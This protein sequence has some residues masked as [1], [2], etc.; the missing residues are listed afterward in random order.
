[1][2]ESDFAVGEHDDSGM[3]GQDLPYTLEGKADTV[4]TDALENESD[5]DTEPRA[6]NRD[7]WRNL[8]AFWVIG[9]LNNSAYVIMNAGASEI[10]SGAVGLVYLCNVAPSLLTK[11]TLPY[12]ADKVPYKVRMIIC[13]LAMIMSF[14]LVGFG[15][16]L[17]IQLLGVACSAF[18]SGLGEASILALAS[19]YHATSTLTA[20]SS[21]T[22]FAGVLGYAWVAVIHQYAKVSL[23]ATVLSGIVLAVGYILSYFYLLGP[24]TAV[25]SSPTTG[26]AG[27]ATEGSNSVNA[28]LDNNEEDDEEA[29]LLS[30]LNDT[31][32]STA[33]KPSSQLSGYERFCFIASLWRYII[34]LII[35]YFSEYAIQAGAW[36][37]F[38]FPITSKA[39]R[40]KFYVTANWMYQ[41]G[42]F[43][44]RSS[45][46]VYQADLATLWALPVIQ[47]GLLVFF[48]LDSIF[49][50][51]WDW[52][53]LSVCIVTGL[54]GGAVYVNAFTLISKTVEPH[55][56]ELALT[57]ASVGDSL[58]I[59][60]SNIS[61][62]FIQGCLFRWNNLSGARYSC[63][64]CASLPPS[65]NISVASF[66]LDSL[67]S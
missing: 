49:H 12:W 19:K 55:R 42:V 48:C 63:T 45:G 4:T 35:V 7:T 30:N 20:W 61:S 67:T 64:C 11:I 36:A 41:L 58:G 6:L 32:N 22:G 59:L 5:V 50:F 57:S 8:A 17:Q 60:M 25:V 29:T 53:L 37:V 65:Q 62:I 13:T 52:S 10:S 43:I 24:P 16:N 9:A 21:G 1:M 23:K 66:Q 27:N 40:D 14:V 2:S 44:S 39:A 31:Q 47:A 26:G 15:D 46:T 56:V 33:S 38:G 51:W 3:V 34:P 18:Q 28:A 54:I